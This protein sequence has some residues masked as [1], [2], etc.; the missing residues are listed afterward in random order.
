M[1]EH[2]ENDRPRLARA[3]DRPIR[4]RNLRGATLAEELGDAP[5]LLCFLRHFG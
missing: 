2:R 1:T 4:G 3:L 5:T